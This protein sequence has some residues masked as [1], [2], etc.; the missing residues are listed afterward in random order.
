[1]TCS[2]WDIFP[3]FKWTPPEDFHGEFFVNQAQQ[4]IITARCE[5][6]KCSLKMVPSGDFRNRSG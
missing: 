1:M 2:D 3:T 5:L 4:R 6:V